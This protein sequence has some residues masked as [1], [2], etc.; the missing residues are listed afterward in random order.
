MTLVIAR[1]QFEIRALADPAPD[2]CGMVVSG[3]DPT[4]ARQ[5][6]VP[7][8]RPQT[9]ARPTAGGDSPGSRAGSRRGVIRPSGDPTHRT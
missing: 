2:Q 8:V 7:H 5:R 9:T 6:E 4:A 1:L 3:K